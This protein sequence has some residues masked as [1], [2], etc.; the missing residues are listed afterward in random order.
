MELMRREHGW[1]V[2]GIEFSTLPPNL[3]NLNIFCGEMGSAPFEL[4]SFDIV[5]AWAVLEHVYHPRA[6]LRVVRN[7]LKPGGSVVILV[8]NFDSIPARIMHHDDVPRHLT[9][10]T[11]RTL[12]RMLLLEGLTPVEWM[13][14]QDVYSGSVR[15]WLNFLIKRAAGE[16]IGDIQAQNRSLERWG[17]FETSIHGRE[18]KFMRRIDRLDIWMTPKLDRILDGIALGFIMIVHAKKI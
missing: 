16:P 5:T 13:C 9:M 15:G 7:F 12:Q 6:T 18:S 17:E 1:E 4:E 2:A 8:P 10:F 11:R 3:Y 14:S